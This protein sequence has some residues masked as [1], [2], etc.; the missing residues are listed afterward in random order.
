MK[1]CIA[2]LRKSLTDHKSKSFKCLE[3]KLKNEFF[4]LIFIRNFFNQ[5]SEFIEGFWWWS[6]QHRRRVTQP[7][8]NFSN[9]RGDEG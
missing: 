9:L 1:G 6:L 3:N 8:L 7:S 4:G 2:S 5:I